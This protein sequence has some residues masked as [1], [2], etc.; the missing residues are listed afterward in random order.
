M[1]VNGKCDE[2]TEQDL[3]T[4]GNNQG[5][6]K[7]TTILTEVRAAISQWPQIAKQA[8]VSNEMTSMIARYLT[9]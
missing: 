1:S 9:V 2:I 6:P 7:P 5:I 3:L 8:G 4:V